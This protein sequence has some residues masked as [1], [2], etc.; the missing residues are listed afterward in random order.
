MLPLDTDILG[1]E[2][3]R[4]PNFDNYT[5]AWIHASDGITLFDLIFPIVFV[6]KCAW[7]NM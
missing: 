4:K 3:A 5:R 2:N 7:Y 6:F 1:D